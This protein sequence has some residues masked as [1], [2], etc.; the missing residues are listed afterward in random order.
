MESA[1]RYQKSL[2]LIGGPGPG[3]DQL[4]LMLVGIGAL[5]ACAT[6]IPGHPAFDLDAVRREVRFPPREIARLNCKR[7]MDR[8]ASIVRWYKA[9]TSR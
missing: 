4:H 1:A 9:A 8:P 7:K 5:L 3:R 6:A 2:Q